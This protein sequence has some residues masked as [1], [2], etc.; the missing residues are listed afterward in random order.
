[1]CSQH[2][3]KHA[4]ITDRFGNVHSGRIVNVTRSRVYIQPNGPRPRGA[5]GMGFYGRGYG[6]YPYYPAYG[7]GLGFITGLAI[8]GLFFF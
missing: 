2:R 5:F 7:I 1:M 6:Y 3:G 4:R 8:G